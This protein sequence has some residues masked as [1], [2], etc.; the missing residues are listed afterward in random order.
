MKYQVLKLAFRPLSNTV[1]DAM[2]TVNTQARPTHFL[3]TQTNLKTLNVDV[4]P[5]LNQFT[6]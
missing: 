4:F 3:Y 6:N 5:V 1:P 2:S